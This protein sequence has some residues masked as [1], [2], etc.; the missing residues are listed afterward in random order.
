MHDIFVVLAGLILGVLTYIG[1][2]QFVAWN[3]KQQPIFWVAC[4]GPILLLSWVNP[5]NT[6]LANAIYAVCGGLIISEV[7]RPKLVAF[8]TKIQQKMH[9]DTDLYREPGSRTSSTS[10]KS[11]KNRKKPQK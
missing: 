2:R 4:F 3:A 10:R 6:Q 9:G 7:V 1:V 5:T 8:W 11:D